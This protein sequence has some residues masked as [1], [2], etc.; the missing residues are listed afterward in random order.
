MKQRS[1]RSD[2]GFNKFI[3]VF[4]AVALLV[5]LL[6]IAYVFSVSLSSKQAVESGKV[7]FY[8]VNATIASYKSLFRSNQV[9]V[10][11]KNSM[12]IM[13]VG[14]MFSVIF[15]VI[16]AY[17]LSKAN[18]KGRKIVLGFIL[19][20]MF[21]KSG[22]IPRFVLMKQLGLVNTY[23]SVWLSNL[24]SIF[25]IF[26]LKTSFETVPKSLEEAAKIDGAGDAR[27]LFEVYLF[28]SMPAIISV[29]LFYMVS[30]WNEYY[31]VM[32]FIHKSDMMPI[33]LR[34]QQMIETVS[35]SFLTLSQK[36][37]QMQ[38]TIAGSSIKCAGIVVC[39][40]PMVCISIPLQKYYIKGSILNINKE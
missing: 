9:V 1:K 22:I 5:C 19:F 16:C 32:L 30:W 11:I 26:I 7:L 13:L 33:V 31:T 17:P 36:D 20:T 8:P 21:F 18:L 28:L 4:W 2:K 35:E 40:L 29:A 24:A 12:I 23:F 37:A 15:S 6:P 39:M 27:I 38:Q 3:V 10:A 34:V 25:N 14:T